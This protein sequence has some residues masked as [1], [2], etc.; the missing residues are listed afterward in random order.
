MSSI[1]KDER[2]LEIIKQWKELRITL[3]EFQ[4]DCGGDSMGSTEFTVMTDD[5]DIDAPEIVAYFEDEIYRRVD[6][7]V[8][9]NGHYQGE[10]GVVEITLNEVDE[11]FFSYD[12]QSTSQWS[13]SYSNI[14]QVELTQEEA[15]FIKTYI[16]SIVGGSDDSDAVNYSQDFIMSDKQ[17]GMLTDICERMN[18]MA[19][20]L[21]I[22]GVD[23]GAEMDSEWYRYEYQNI[24]GENN[25]HVEVTKTFTVLKEGE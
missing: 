20:E 11:P 19:S 13:E 9:S 25:M 10:S 6:F 22:E 7:Y 21:E 5:G 4:F 1:T 15:D 18:N 12:K 23:E 17:E 24:D 3:V 8:D 16:R 14:G 2:E